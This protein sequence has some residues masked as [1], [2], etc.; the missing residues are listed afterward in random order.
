[1]RVKVLRRHTYARKIRTPGGE[2]DMPNPRHV[3]I[4]EAIGKVQR[5]PEI[6]APPVEKK[7]PAP[8]KQKPKKK[9]EAPAEKKEKAPTRRRYA[10]KDMVAV[11]EELPEVQ[12]ALQEPDLPG[13]KNDDEDLDEI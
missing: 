4:F 12:V 11:E 2:Y 5:L 6:V 10:R 9:A 8:V 1:M 7:K 3:R 13:V